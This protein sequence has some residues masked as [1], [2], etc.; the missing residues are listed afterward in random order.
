M[1]YLRNYLKLYQTPAFAPYMW[2][3]RIYFG[4]LQCT[5]ILLI[6][7]LHYQ[8]AP[9]YQ[10]IRY[11]VEEAID[12]SMTQYQLAADFS[13]TNENPSSSKSQVP[14]FIQ[15]LV[16][17]HQ[18]LDSPKG[19]NEPPTPPVHWKAASG[20]TE[21]GTVPSSG[22]GQDFIATLSDLQAWSAQLVKES[23]GFSGV[24]A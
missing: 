7:L 23:E 14:V 17:L 1:S 2:L 8:R 19:S 9:N 12:H 24:S 15:V 18:R 22:V 3:Y 13:L 5:F 10:V 16:D 4:P 11:C 6:Y 21:Y 20:E